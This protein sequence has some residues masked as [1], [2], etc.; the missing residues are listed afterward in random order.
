MAKRGKGKTEDGEG[1]QPVIAIV[2]LGWLGRSLGH[3][4]QAVKTSYQVVGHDREPALARAARDSGAVD[5][6][7]WNL[8][9]T[10]EEADLVFLTE[11][12]AQMR[13]SLEIIAPELRPGSLVT[14]TAPRKAEIMALAERL[15]PEGISFVGGHPVITPPPGHQP[16]DDPLA[17]RSRF[18]GATWCLSPLPTAS[19][20]AMRVLGNLVAAVG[21]KAYYVDPVEHDS[22][23]SGASL[24]PFVSAMALVRHLGQSPSSEDFARLGGSFLL[25]VLD[26]PEAE[27]AG[28]LADAR[29]DRQGLASW[30]DQAV[31]S[32]SR[33]RDAARAEEGAAF[34]HLLAEAEATRQRWLYPT[35]EPDERARTMEDI[36]EQSSLRNMF[37]GR[38]GRRDDPASG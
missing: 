33:L 6:A 25:E 21:A 28:W 19:D 23:V 11:P 27:V 30:L 5:R 26:R 15:L 18:E 35:D 9:A 12:G 34:E 8:I 37:F 38:L 10:V 31:D 7:D 36:A 22:L 3:A 32:L 2:G 14:D 13:Q 29:A 4:L 1:R 24:M 20:A 16:E 17:A